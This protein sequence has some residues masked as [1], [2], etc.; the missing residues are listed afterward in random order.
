MT[1]NDERGERA[2]AAEA[3]SAPP[4]A[5]DGG[6]ADTSRGLLRRETAHRD[7]RGGDSGDDGKGEADSDEA[8]DAAIA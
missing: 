1:A 2:A 8:A 7:S 3:A 5:S 4:E 6:A